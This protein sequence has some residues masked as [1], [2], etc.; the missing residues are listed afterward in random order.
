MKGKNQSLDYFLVGLLGVF[1]GAGIIIVSIDYLIVNP[2]NPN[3][4]NQ[5]IIKNI[6]ING[7]IPFEEN[8][9]AILQ[10][11][12]D[13]VVNINVVRIVQTFFGPVKSEGT[14]SGVIVTKDGYIV[15][16]DHVVSD[17]SNIT[18]VLSNGDEF[19]AILVGN[20][21]LNDVA[22]IKIDP[23]YEL[24][25]AKIG[26]SDKIRQGE[27][28]VAIGSPFRLQN[29]VTFGIVS[30]LN[31]TLISEGGFRIEKVIQT[32]ATINP[33]NS[34]GPLLN[35]KGEVIGINTAIISKSGGSEGIG[36]AIPINTVKKIYTQ[37]IET[38]KIERP[39]LGVTITDV[40]KQIKDAW[41]LGVDK[42]VLIIDIVKDGPADKAGLRETIS[43]P[44]R[45]DFV[46]GDI[47]VGIGGFEI[48]N[49]SDLLNILM[50]YKPG[51]TI[52]VEVY[53]EGEFLTFSVTLGTRPENM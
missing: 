53:R 19:E 48:S 34:G 20:D 23:H 30:A 21:P 7:T 51:D 22:V 36:F 5:T 25:P 4:T 49:N 6:Y 43:R 35:S 46:L 28:V 10:N 9:I 38:G 17:S 15:T 13:S 52:E 3:V 27:L 31:R 47:I 29:T 45:K 40:T 41:N 2:A 39:W 24:D 37:L 1:V 44:G 42:G 33:G 26:D 11:S 50:K 32:D 18:V 14:G 8:V 16:N 12:K